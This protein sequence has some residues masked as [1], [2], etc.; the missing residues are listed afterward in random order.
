MTRVP[1]LLVLSVVLFLGSVAFA[2]TADVSLTPQISESTDRF[3]VIF[4]L[5]NHGP[6]VARKAVLTFDVPPG[7]NVEGISYGGG[8]SV[9]CKPGSQ[10]P[11]RCEV[12]D[13][14]VM[15]PFH[16]GQI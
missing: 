1:R 2:Q 11:I 4:A 16:Y 8:D 13:L 14:H 9:T 6:D 15:L 5:V 10:R 12:G 3:Q 7:A